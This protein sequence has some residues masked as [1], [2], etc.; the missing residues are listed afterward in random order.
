M[1]RRTELVDLLLDVA[2]EREVDGQHAA[3]SRLR[4]VAVAISSANCKTLI[5]MSF[6]RLQFLHIVI[7]K[8]HS[9]GKLA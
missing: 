5:A 2:R 9:A 1:D 3:A 6:V 8:G 4:R 7:G